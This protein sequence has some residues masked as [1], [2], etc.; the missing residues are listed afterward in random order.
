MQKSFDLMQDWFLDATEIF[1]KNHQIRIAHQTWNNSRNEFFKNIH[2]TEL[3]KKKVNEGS[4]IG[5]RKHDK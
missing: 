1:K 3:F 5:K 2:E 4:K